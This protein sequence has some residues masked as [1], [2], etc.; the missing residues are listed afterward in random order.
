VLAA[1]EVPM[2]RIWSAAG[3]AL[4]ALAGGGVGALVGGNMTGKRKKKSTVM[5]TTLLGAGLGAAIY[6][7]A[8]AQ[9]DAA[10]SQL[11]PPRFP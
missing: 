11:P 5:E 3:S 7:A 10:P 2:S 6:G 4:A 9:D 1:A 8:T